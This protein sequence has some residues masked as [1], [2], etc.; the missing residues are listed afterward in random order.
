MEEILILEEN[1]FERRSLPFSL[2][3]D[4]VWLV[5]FWQLNCDLIVQGRDRTCQIFII[6]LRACVECFACKYHM[7]R[8]CFCVYTS[9]LR[10]I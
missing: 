7:M 5:L 2:W 4:L 8:P 6:I 1:V 10:I 9:A 3:F